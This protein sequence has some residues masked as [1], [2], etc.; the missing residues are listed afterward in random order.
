[1][2]VLYDYVVMMVMGNWEW[3]EAK[4][5]SLLCP[6]CFCYAI[7]SRLTLLN[8]NIHSYS[9]LS[10]RRPHATLCNPKSCSDDC[11]F[12]NQSSEMAVAA[13]NET[14]GVECQICI[15]SGIVATWSRWVPNRWTS[16]P[17]TLEAPGETTW[18]VETPIDYN[19]QMHA[20]PFPFASPSNFGLSH[21]PTALFE[22]ITYHSISIT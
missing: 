13:I 3:E 1:M 20:K 15:C 21:A 6:G 18:K 7:L 17:P 22:T 5:G 9:N 12:K 14:D 16:K 19:C 2:E 8:F 10:Y 11:A 4:A